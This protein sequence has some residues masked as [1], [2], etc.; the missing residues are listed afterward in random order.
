MVTR[1]CHLPLA[2]TNKL[3]AEIKI[4]H[5][6]VDERGDT[7]TAGVTYQVRLPARNGLLVPELCLGADCIV[8]GEHLHGLWGLPYRDGTLR[9][10]LRAHHNPFWHRAMDQAERLAREEIRELNQALKDRHYVEWAK[11]KWSA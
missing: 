6:R 2:Y 10:H 4:E 1:Y 5:R 3:F 8:M 9:Y 7:Q 11:D